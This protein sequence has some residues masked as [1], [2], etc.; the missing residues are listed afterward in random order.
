[1][2]VVGS[3]VVEK[4]RTLKPLTH[5]AIVAFGL[6][7]LY[8]LDLTGPVISIE[9]DL[10]YHLI[11]SA[12]SVIVPIIVYVVALTLLLTGLLW[13]AERPGRL[14][15]VI[16]SAFLLALP[17]VLLHTIAN[18]SGTEIPD[19]ITNLVAA[20]CLIALLVI[21]FGW[22]KFLR[23]FDSI[24][25]AAA[26]ILGFFA[27]SGLLIFSQ[28]I[29]NAWQAR[30]LNPSPVLHQTQLNQTQ[31][32]QTQRPRIVWILL[33]ELSYQQLY[34]TRFPGLELP[35]FDQLA[36]QSTVFTHTIPAG[37]FTRYILP[38]LFTG[39]PS[40]AV[41]V[42]ARGMLLALKD[43]ATG[44]WN[45]FH[46]HQTV[47]QDAIDAGY[48]TGLAGWYNP[49]CRILPEV[50][51]HCFWTYRESTPANL[52][53][54]R[55]LAVD[56][57]RPFRRLWLDTRHLF[58]HGPGAPSEEARD[59]HQHTA[60]YRNLLAAGDAQLNDPS[61]DFLFLHMPIPHPFGFYDR[62]TKTFTTHHTSYIDNLALADAYLAHVRQILEQQNQWDST[63][64]VIM[65]DHS[66]RTTL[67]WEDSMT[68]TDEDQAASHNGAFDD[69]PAYMVKLPNQHTPARI[70]HPWA[71]VRTRA[72]LDALL[73]NR[74]HTP[75]DLQTWAAQP[76]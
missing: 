38:T 23:R 22:K 36:A 4:K 51:D 18:F 55:T 69:R 28:L 50:L 30:H 75:T 31:P 65:G 72:L 35:A 42:S 9:H 1:M 63:T 76:N 20:L 5:P 44:K 47:F 46:Q 6:A 2:P 48:I 33:D 3:P 14:R 58:G 70:D 59:I 41:D 53:P 54:N 29:W 24:Q 67:I 15:V 73:Q 25:P 8:L 71:A 74:L 13:L 11:G 19:W 52:S 32:N 61:I 56:L 49:Y 40:K 26:A 27:F 16:W 57:L 12:S 64:L 62:K 21:S 60:D 43:P 34:E 7:N 39:L 66:W 68:W 45:R 37:Q 17:S 10:I